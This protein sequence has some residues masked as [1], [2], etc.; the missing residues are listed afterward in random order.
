MPAT[1]LY[2]AQLDPTWHDWVQ[3]VNVGNAP[4]RVTCIGRNIEAKTIWTAEH[5]LPPYHTWTPAVDAPK[6]SVSLEVRSDGQPIVGERHCHSGSQVLDFPGASVFG[7]TVGRRLFFAELVAGAVDWFRF[8]NV[9][10]ADAHV[11]FVVRQVATA[12]VVIQRSQVVKPFGW[13]E[14]GDQVMGGAVQGTV[15]VVSTQP[16][17]GERHLHYKGGQIAVGQ[18]GQVLEA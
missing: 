18:L 8:L 15:E 17:V 2:F 13:W 1:T 5:T 11:S 16:I 3:V 10:Q 14:V 6:Q 4:A 7:K 9:G 12:R